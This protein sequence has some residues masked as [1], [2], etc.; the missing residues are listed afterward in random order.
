MHL[1]NWPLNI[2]QSIIFHTSLTGQLDRLVAYGLANG[3][4]R[5]HNERVGEQTTPA[6]SALLCLEQ[7]EGCPAISSLRHGAHHNG[8]VCFT[9]FF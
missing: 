9:G 8:T 1:S 6:T 5:G 4:T 2:K 7:L 3:N